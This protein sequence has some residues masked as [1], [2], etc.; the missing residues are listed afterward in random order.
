MESP[1]GFW[2]HAGCWIQLLNNGVSCW[3]LI[4]VFVM[5][6][7]QV[8]PLCIA[9]L[10]GHSDCADVLIKEAGVGVDFR[11]AE[12]WTMVM[13]TLSNSVNEETLKQLKFLVEQ[14]KADVKLQDGDGWN[15]VSLPIM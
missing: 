3:I 11:D 2:I 10:K 4:T 9:F 14:K 6:L 15:A 1:V 5:L 12:G 7:C 8:P 13:M